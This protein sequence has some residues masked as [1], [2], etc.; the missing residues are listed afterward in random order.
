MNDMWGQQR[1]FR[2]ASDLQAIALLAR[3]AHRVAKRAILRPTS[4]PI[5]DLRA[6]LASSFYCR[7]RLIPFD[8]TSELLELECVDSEGRCVTGSV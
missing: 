1:P 8:Q 2:P 3:Y 4:S 7:L 6:V 5:R